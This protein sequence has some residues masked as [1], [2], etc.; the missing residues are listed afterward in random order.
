MCIRFVNQYNFDNDLKMLLA[1]TENER[2]VNIRRMLLWL[3]SFP[4]PDKRDVYS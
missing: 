4:I 3:S 2:M 1:A